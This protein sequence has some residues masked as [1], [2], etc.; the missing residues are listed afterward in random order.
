MSDKYKLAMPQVIRIEPSGLCNFRCC[1]CPVGLGLNKTA[2]IMSRETFDKIYERIKHLHIRVAVLYHGG[3]P[4]LNKNIFYFIEKMAKISGRMKMVSNGSLLTD[5]AIEKVLNSFLE[6]IEFS[7]DGQ[8]PEENNKIRV[9][10][11]FEKISKQIIKLLEK[12]KK[13]GSNIR[14]VISNTQ[15]S[16]RNSKIEEIKPPAYL[17]ETFKDWLGEM[18]ILSFYAIKWPGYPG[19]INKNKKAIRNSCDHIQSTITIRWNGDIAPCCYDLTS[20]KIM[21]NILQ[22]SLEEI[23]NNKA[24]QDMREMIDNFKPPLLCLGCNVLYENNYMLADEI[25]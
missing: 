2:G 7:F 21:G 13:M 15:I 14:V 6:L 4:L 11:D 3:E 9:G 1:H 16:S 22:T 8:S 18:S 5:E 17:L 19:E 25:I 10:S 23:W 24:Y 12:R 20:K